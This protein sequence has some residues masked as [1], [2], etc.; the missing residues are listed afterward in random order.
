M[1][2]LSISA[3]KQYGAE[4]SRDVE[5]AGRFLDETLLEESERTQGRIGGT[6]KVAHGRIATLEAEIVALEASLALAAA[7]DAVESARGEDACAVAAV[8]AKI[9]LCR[10][11]IASIRRDIESL[12][13]MRAELLDRCD[14]YQTEAVAEEAQFLDIGNSLVRALAQHAALMGGAQDP[15]RL[16]VGVLEDRGLPSFESW[17]SNSR[18]GSPASFTLDEGLDCLDLA[19]DIRT[20]ATLPSTPEADFAFDCLT[21]VGAVRESGTSV[22]IDNLRVG[23]SELEGRESVGHRHPVQG[24]EWFSSAGEIEQQVGSVDSGVFYWRPDSGR[25]FGGVL[26]N[27]RQ[28]TAGEICE[29]YGFDA[30]KFENGYPVFPKEVV[31]L[32]LEL[33]SP[34]GKRAK[35]LKEADD[36]LV[37]SGGKGVPPEFSGKVRSFMKAC[38]GGEWFAARAQVE[39]FRK[40]HRLT[41][42]EHEDMR[43]VQL[44]PS[45]VHAMVAHDGGVS[46]AKHR[47]KYEEQFRLL[48]NAGIGRAKEVS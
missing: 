30:I 23:D 44:I 5:G 28:M 39:A 12:K 1:A 40:V 42:H 14:L 18:E 33:G 45:E 7:G 38:G 47:E 46:N 19:E 6:I 35:N 21:S 32:S 8:M 10:S 11:K 2:R 16:E 34:M 31:V 26:G 15:F 9:E 17:T 29:K 27:P 13:A 41:W 24:G 25:I 43:E 3:L 37:R 4:L 22:T 48:A 36:L 20:I